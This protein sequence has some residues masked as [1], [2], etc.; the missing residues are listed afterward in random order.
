MDSPRLKLAFV[1]RQTQRCPQPY[2][3]DDGCGQHQQKGRAG[4]LPPGS[5]QLSASTR[6]MTAPTRLSSAAPAPARS[7]PRTAK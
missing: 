1:R 2:I 5:G 6:A 7:S 3:G 4:A